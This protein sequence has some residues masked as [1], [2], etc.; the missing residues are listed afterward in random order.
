MV[1]V[2]APAPETTAG[3]AAVHV[4]GSIAPAGLE[5]RAQVNVTVPVKPPL[6]VTVM[7]EVALPPA[8]AIVAAVPLN[9]YTEGRFTVTG[10]VAVWETPPALPV[11]VTV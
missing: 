3:W 4:G 7:V 10:T 8:A 5:V 6:G 2:T 1:E 9:V 11:T